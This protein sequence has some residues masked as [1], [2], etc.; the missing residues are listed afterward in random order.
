MWE[1]PQGDAK[2]GVQGVRG[3]VDSA[4]PLTSSS[5]AADYGGSRYHRPNHRGGYDDNYHDN[6]FRYR[7]PGQGHCRC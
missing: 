6:G 4:C 3:R 2:C 7:G 5:Y 1:D